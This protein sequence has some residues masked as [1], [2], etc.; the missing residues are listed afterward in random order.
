[1]ASRDVPHLVDGK[2]LI[3]QPLG[4]GGTG[5]VYRAR[6]VRLDRLVA[7][8]VIHP[9]LLGDPAAGQRFLHEAQIV[10]RLRHPAIVSVHDFGTFGDNGAY[11][12]ME[13][14]RGED[15][16]HVLQ[17]EGR[18]EPRRALS[19]LTTVCGAVEAAHRE[20]VLHGDLKPENIL[21]PDSGVDAKVLDFGF[22]RVLDV[23]PAPPVDAATLAAAATALIVGTPAYM[24]PEQLRGGAVDARAD[25]FSLGVIAYEMLT[26]ELPFGSGSLAELVLAHSRDAARIRGAPP[27]LSRAVHAALEAEPDRR[28]ASAQ[29]LAHLL[30]AAAAI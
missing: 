6:D 10:A 3:E 23:R 18:L 5:A 21:L 19:I 8:K 2:Y 17:R 11:L 15:L 9:E 1:M 4:R 14:V 25:V 28:P 20:Q 12:V 27:A 29:A 22:A 16:R 7:L 26:G 24:A 13:L 30:S